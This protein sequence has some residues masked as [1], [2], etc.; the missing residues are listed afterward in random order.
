MPKINKSTGTFLICAALIMLCAFVFLT[1]CSPADGPKSSNA[2][3][4]SI[5]VSEGTLTPDF[6]PEV[7]EYTVTVPRIDRG[8]NCYR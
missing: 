5:T 3:L 1:S 8:R 7:T 6:S 4:S 2:D